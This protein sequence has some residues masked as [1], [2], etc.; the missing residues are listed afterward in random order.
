M[1]VK[2]LDAVRRTPTFAHIGDLSFP[3]AC[4]F[5]HKGAGRPHYMK[6]IYVL[7]GGRFIPLRQLQMWAAQHHKRV[8][9][10]EKP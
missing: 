9:I 3:Q 2:P 5:D 10:T 8:V 4:E 1:K 6:G 7:P